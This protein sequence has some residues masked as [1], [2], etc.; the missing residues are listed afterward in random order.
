M[1]HLGEDHWRVV[2]DLFVEGQM[3][4]RGR[5]NA[6]LEEFLRRAGQRFAEDSE[7]AGRTWYWLEGL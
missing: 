7:L 5:P 3:E 6:L 2:F 1:D 4:G